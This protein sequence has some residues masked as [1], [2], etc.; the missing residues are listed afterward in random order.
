MMLV[1]SEKH[2]YNTLSVKGIEKFQESKILKD[3]LRTLETHAK[4]VQKII[5]YEISMNA[6]Y[7]IF[8]DIMDML[9]KSKEMVTFM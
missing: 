9:R 6:N 3:K 2:N 7:S 5:D 1:E 4:D 8:Q